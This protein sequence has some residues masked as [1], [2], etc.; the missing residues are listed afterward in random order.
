M[1]IVQS[2]QKVEIL[3]SN[4]PSNGQYS[5]REGNPIVNFHIGAGS[6]LLRSSSLRV[7]GKIEVLKADGTPVDNGDLKSS[8]LVDVRLSSRVGVHSCFQNVS[9]ASGESNQTLESVRQYGRLLSSLLPSSHS[10]EDFLATQGITAK[11]TAEDNLAGALINN[12][13]SFSVPLYCGIFQSDVPL[14]MGQNGFRGMS[15]TLELASDQQVL[16]GTNAGDTSGAFYRLS[17]LSISCDML[18]PTPAEQQKMEVASSGTFVFNTLQNLYS[19]I[20]SSDATQTF[21]L[22]SSQVL[23]VFHNFIP[24]PHSNSYSHDS[25]ATTSLLN[26][27]GA[28]YTSDATLKKVSFSRDGIK[29]GLDYDLDCETQSS[30]GIPETGVDITATNAIQPFSSL[31]KILDQPRMFPFGTKDQEIYAPETLQKSSVVDE[32]RN[33]LIGLAL[34]R[35]SNQG[36]DFRSKSYALRIQSTLDGNSPLSIY[37]YYLARNVLQYSPQG[38]SVSS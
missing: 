5:F 8:G 3:P 13:T 24:V 6:K 33:F 2:V 29:L 4:Q 27:V 28:S 34:D 14:P 25:F 16:S 21:N 10:S 20:N 17:D 18:L 26:K 30:A 23:S 12:K 37:T 7:N 9:I 36:M 15:L 35:V 32:R 38:I 19:V 1:S 31:T 22:A 11:A